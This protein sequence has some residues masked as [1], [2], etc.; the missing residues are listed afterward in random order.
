[1]MKDLME[2]DTLLNETEMFSSDDFSWN[3][4]IRSI[5]YTKFDYDNFIGKQ[6]EAINAVLCGRDVLVVSHTGSGKSLIYIITGYHQSGV[7]VV[8]FPTISLMNEQYAFL[9]YHNIGVAK[10]NNE[11][12]FDKRKLILEDLKKGLTKFL[13]L[14]PGNVLITLSLI[15]LEMLSSNGSIKEVLHQL[16]LNNKLLRFVVDEA[17]L[18]HEYQY[19]RYDYQRIGDAIS[20]YN[21]VPI[22]ALTATATTEVQQTIKS[23]L[24]IEDCV[25]FVSET[26][27]RSNLYYEVIRIENEKDLTKIDVC[28][29]IINKYH[30][31]QSGI[32]Y[33]WK[34]K[35]CDAIAKGLQEK[36]ISCV[37]YHAGFTDILR[38]KLHKQWYNDTTK[39]I[40]ATHESFGLGIDKTDVRF[41]IHAQ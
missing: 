33:A 28:F 25:S 30:Y 2:V 26:F 34:Q 3:E 18:V 5:M 4:D 1:M 19:F 40:V 20:A 15:Q 7:T 6:K 8:L 36:G 38:N 22:L 11:T 17:H 13:F 16:H 41:I 27:D 31:N 21:N 37:S 12:P 39:I 32:I 9:Q 24:K 23:R 35:H 14:T 10:F 29:E